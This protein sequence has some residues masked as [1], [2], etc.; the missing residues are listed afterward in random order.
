MTT[1]CSEIAVGAP[2]PR[3]WRFA[4]NLLPVVGAV[5]LLIG[6]CGDA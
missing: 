5:L 1:Q 4:A 3:R 2:A 6:L